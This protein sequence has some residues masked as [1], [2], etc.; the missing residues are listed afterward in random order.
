MLNHLKET[1]IVLVL[2]IEN[3]S[4]TDKFRP[5]SLTNEIYEII[6][7]ILVYRFKSLIRKIIGPMQSAFIPGRSII[8]TRFTLQLSP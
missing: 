8:G 4:T 3:A 1:F 6:S 5:I 7:R 2:K